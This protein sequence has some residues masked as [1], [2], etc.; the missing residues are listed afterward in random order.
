MRDF[1]PAHPGEVLA[2]DFLKPLAMK[3][4]ADPRKAYGPNEAPSELVALIGPELE[5][6]MEEEKPTKRINRTD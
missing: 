1:T 5:R 4:K 3:Q 2:D 6:L